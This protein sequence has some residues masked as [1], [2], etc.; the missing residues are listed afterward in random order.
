[1]PSG[2]TGR[3]GFLPALVKSIRRSFPCRHP[4]TGGSLK[5]SPAGTPLTHRFLYYPYST[6]AAAVCQPSFCPGPQPAGRRDG[7]SGEFARN[8]GLSNR[9]DGELVGRASEE[10][11][12]GE[13]VGAA[14]VDRKLLCEIVQRIECVAGIEA[15]LVLAVAALHLTVVPRGIRANQLMPDAQLSSRPLKQSRPLC[16]GWGGCGA[17]WTVRAIPQRSTVTAYFIRE[18]V[19]FASVFWYREKSPFGQQ[20]SPIYSGF[21]QETFFVSTSWWSE[22]HGIRTPPRLQNAAYH[23]V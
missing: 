13:V 7:P 8:V 19:D 5:G 20:K 4:T 10:G 1:M 18:N 21:S 22:T 14:V 12:H 9:L 23:A 16:A 17:A 15:F 3:D 6:T 2:I 11:P